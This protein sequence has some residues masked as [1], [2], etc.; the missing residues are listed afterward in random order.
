MHYFLLHPTRSSE[1]LKKC[2]QAWDELIFKGESSNDY[3]ILKW[4][5]D[6]RVLRPF[7]PSNGTE[8]DGDR[9]PVPPDWTG[10]P[11][12]IRVEEELWGDIRQ[13]AGRDVGYERLLHE[14]QRRLAEGDE[15]HLV[16]AGRVV[17]RLRG[18]S[19]AEG[20]LRVVQA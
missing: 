15:L 16:H 4:E 18:M 5:R 9:W 7:D 2:G 13:H 14:I 20:N 3:F 1:R 17:R 6:G 8:Q 19:D 11:E 12:P 10:E